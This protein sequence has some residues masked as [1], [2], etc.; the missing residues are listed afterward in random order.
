MPQK[1]KRSYIDS[2]IRQNREMRNLL[3]TWPAREVMMDY[4]KEW[5]ERREHFLAENTEPHEKRE[6]D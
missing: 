5:N 6:R 1:I 4:E 3:E 2:L